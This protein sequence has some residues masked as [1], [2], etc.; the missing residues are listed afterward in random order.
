MV[1]IYNVLNVLRQL[2]FLAIGVFLLPYC[3]SHDVTKNMPL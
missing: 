2:L 1:E 3:S